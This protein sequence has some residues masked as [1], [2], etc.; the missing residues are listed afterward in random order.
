MKQM[1]ENLRAMGYDVYFN[2]E[3]GLGL[4]N[5]SIEIPDK[6][7]TVFH[8]GDFFCVKFI[9]EGQEFQQNIKD[10]N[11]LYDFLKDFLSGK[12]TLNRMDEL[13]ITI[14]N[15]EIH[16][17]KSKSEKIFSVIRKI[18]NIVVGA[19]LAVFSLIFLVWGLLYYI[20][21]TSL[22][23]LADATPVPMAIA[24]IVIGAG[25][26]HHGI[27]KNPL[28]LGGTVLYGLGMILMSFGTSLIFLL[29]SEYND[30]PKV[31]FFGTIA[32]F[33]M[34][35]LL[36][37]VMLIGGLSYGKTETVCNFHFLKRI[38]V[39]PS[40]DDL[41][42][43]M[44]TIKEKSAKEAV[45]IRLNPEKEPSVFDSKLGGLP[46]WD[47]S[48]T[49]PV[50]LY[51]NKMVL[52]AQ[53]NLSQ[54]PENTHL[55]GEGILQFFLSDYN[56]DDVKVVYHKSINYSLT[57]ED[58]ELLDIPD[59]GDTFTGECGIDL[60]KTVMPISSYDSEA[61]KL[62]HNTAKELGI[63]IDETLRFF[64]L[65]DDDEEYNEIWDSDENY[66]LGNPIFI[67]YDIRP[68]NSKY[69]TLLFQ[70]SSVRNS[71]FS[72]IWGDCGICNFFIN[73]KDLS[74]M[75]F[76]DVFFGWDCS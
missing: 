75:N 41:K 58:I 72:V 42:R 49:Y 1:C 37:M 36:G 59:S 11:V 43:L 4:Y 44:D 39:L 34:F 12:I 23:W 29:C 56:E 30:T 22:N 57:S 71:K 20:D 21:Y 69:N 45:L 47:S 74:N 2:P 13:S 10:Y 17:K 33:I 40:D 68:D 32:V 73:D 67:N 76:D 31:D 19:G 9:F 52:L 60:E 3:S 15:W 16:D 70:L 65:C 54:L 46:Y 51:G 26:V 5:D 18:F 27:T 8:D 28:P 64:E 6:K 61:D 14:D 25:M 35:M 24:G 66:L 50:D 48:R 55:S 7:M 63:S 53:F 62:L 38:P